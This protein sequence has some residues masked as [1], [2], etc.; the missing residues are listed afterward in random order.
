MSR[1][2]ASR[3]QKPKV[4]HSVSVSSKYYVTVKWGE[5]LTDAA[6]ASPHD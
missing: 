5:F 6:G 2:E 4:R 1:C 3:G